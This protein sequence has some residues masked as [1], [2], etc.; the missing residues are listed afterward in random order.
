MT[1]ATMALTPTLLAEAAW[2]LARSGDALFRI[3]V[4]TNGRV[5]LLPIWAWDTAGR[6]PRP[7]T[8]TYRCDVASPDGMSSVVLPASEVLHLR[9]ASSAASPWRG[10][11][12]WRGC[13]L[14]AD[15][16]GA[17]DQRLSEESSAASGYLI[18]VADAGDAT[19]GADA[20]SSLELTMK[21]AKGGAVLT[22]THQAGLGAGPGVAPPPE[23]ELKPTRFG[24]NPPESLVT[25]R[26]DAVEEMLSVYGLSPALLDRRAA[27]PAMRE[28][29]R[30]GIRL[31][32]TPLM[33]VI[34]D[35]AAVALD[36][37]GLRF[38][39]DAASAGDVAALARAWRGL[40]GQ[41]AK[42]DPDVARDLVGL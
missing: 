10:V 33:R 4:D 3:T 14:T 24:V 27:G 7:E 32:V 42:M 37:P 29:W 21:G 30:I 25:L 13:S 17:I 34:A 15:M 6:D 26:R 41:E 36:V 35:Q 28:A 5:G 40:V 12:P 38:N 18:P 9:L 2:R 16:L 19:D 22:A 31:G 23:R 8:W 20:T 11:P 1:A 39:L